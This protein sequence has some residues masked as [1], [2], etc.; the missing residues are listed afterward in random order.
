MKSTNKIFKIFL[1]HEIFIDI[2]ISIIMLTFMV[3]LFKF[4]PDDDFLGKT[5]M[6]YNVVEAMSIILTVIDELL[7]DEKIKIF[8][9]QRKAYLNSKFMCLAFRALF[10][11]IVIILILTFINTGS[12]ISIGEGTEKYFSSSFQFIILMMTFIISM[13]LI[14]MLDLVSRNT[15]SFKNKS[16][17][18]VFFLM[19]AYVGYMLLFYILLLIFL[20]NK[21]F[22]ILLI[23]W[24]I[25][26]LLMKTIVKRYKNK[27]EI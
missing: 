7:D 22:I 5:V 13:G 9:F 15:F 19:I 26:I 11:S 25:N 16:S 2:L 27:S 20:E 14:G 18:N 23:S 8:C 21:W 17:Q 3:F 4:F 1:K 10:I 12:K 24:I 6:L